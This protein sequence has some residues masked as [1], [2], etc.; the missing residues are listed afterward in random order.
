MRRSRQT[1]HLIFLLSFLLTWAWALPTYVQSSYLELFVPVHLVSLYLTLA[2]VVAMPVIFF[3]PRLIKRFSNFRVLLAVLAAEAFGLVSLALTTNRFLALPL[4]AAYSVSAMLGGINIDVYLEDVS[5]HDHVGNIRTTLMT[6]NNLAWVVAPLVMGWIAAGERYRLVLLA[7]GA[8]LLPA[9][10]VLA[11]K[12][13]AMRDRSAYRNRPLRELAGLV[14][15]NPNVAKIFSLALTLQFFYFLMVF[16]VPLH[17]HHNL[18]FGWTT[19]GWILSVMLLPFLIL[20]LPAGRVADT[21]LG[22]KEMLIAGLITMMVFTGLIFFVPSR[23]PLVW[24]AVLF[25]TRAGA[26][27]VEAMEEVYF[28]KHIERRDIDLIN[29]F[30]NL[31]PLGRMLGS[32]AGFALVSWLPIPYLFLFLA[33]VL[34]FALKPAL[35]LQDDT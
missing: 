14:W 24:A 11:A 28:F 19:I 33:I 5:D 25:M 35:T 32:L 8:A 4:F 12:R 23:S 18:G 9:I 17:L 2:T 22:E 1:F 6:L 29:L 27:L 10:L 20:Q 16:Y 34:M 21:L 31:T 26:A 30:R 3:Y 15:R 7:A 13:R